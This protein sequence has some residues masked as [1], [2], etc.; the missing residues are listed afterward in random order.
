[1]KGLERRIEDQVRNAAEMREFMKTMGLSEE[2]IERAVKV[3]FNLPEPP[4][5]TSDR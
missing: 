3:K 5:K 4:G 2:T 1:M